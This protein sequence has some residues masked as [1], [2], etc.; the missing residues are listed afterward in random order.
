MKRKQAE[1]TCRVCGCT[2]R[3]CSGCIER[4]GVACH[5]VGADLCS[6]CAAGWGTLIR[7]RRGEP[8]VASARVGGKTLR[9]SSTCSPE[10]ACEALAAKA[11]AAVGASGWGVERYQSLSLAA[12]R[13]A[14]KLSFAEREGGRREH[15]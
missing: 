1:R 2:D 11:A 12:G 8:N 15:V 9:A 5:W 10:E 7:V 4:T 3:D 14:M 13:A 6:A